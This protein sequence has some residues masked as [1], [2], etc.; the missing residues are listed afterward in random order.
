[1]RANARFFSLVIL[2]L[3]AVFMRLVPHPANF[4]PIAAVALFGAAT[5]E[6]RWAAFAV[7]M[8][9]LFLSDLVIGFHS[10]MPAVYFAFA[11]IGVL[12]LVF[13]RDQKSVGRVA[14]TSFAGSILF[15]LITNF[16]VWAQTEMYPKSSDGLLACFIAALPFLQNSIASDLLFN[17]VLFGAWYALEKTFPNAL[18]A[19]A[20]TKVN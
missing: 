16:S 5:F 13:V 3:T 1:L 2:I 20:E 19:F 14:A 9:C 7:P 10:Q 12:G 15:F 11:L 18:S 17:G 4:A 6:S 8:I